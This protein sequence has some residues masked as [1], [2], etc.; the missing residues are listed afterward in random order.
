MSFF[1]FVGSVASAVGKTLKKVAVKTVDLA[2]KALQKVAEFGEKAI[3]KV[4]ETWPKVRTVLKNVHNKVVPPVK[5]A[6]NWLIATAPPMIGPIPVKAILMGARAGVEMADRGLCALFK[7]ENSP[8]LRM[9]DDHASKIFAMMKKVGKGMVIFAEMLKEVDL[10]KTLQRELESL[11]KKATNE[12]EKLVIKVLLALNRLFRLKTKVEYKLEKEDFAS[13]EEYMQVAFSKEIC[14][15]FIADI[16]K[17]ATFDELSRDE[18]PFF[19]DTAEIIIGDN[20]TL[21]DAQKEKFA[22]LVKENL[23]KSFQAA[24]YE[25]MVLFWNS[26]MKVNEENLNEMREKKSELSADV[27]MKKPGASQADLDKLQMEYDALRDEIESHKYYIYATE[28]LQLFYEER[29]GEVMPDVAN[30]VES[31]MEQLAKIISEVFEKNIKFKELGEK[32]E[33]HQRFILDL[34]ILFQEASKNRV[35]TYKENLQ[36]TDRIGEVEE[37]EVVAS[38]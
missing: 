3:S 7:L 12:K 34:A 36:M 1:S 14:G 37:V 22:S 38:A 17:G 9:I 4:K 21:D 30:V 33:E 16:N 10:S 27:E 20:P 26:K 19:F 15:K 25:Q 2:G 29:L 8:I 24:V 28:A 5:T 6:L 13:M 18:L 11:A 31:K 35:D 23:G 32:N